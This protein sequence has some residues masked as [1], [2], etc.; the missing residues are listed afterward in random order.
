MMPLNPIQIFVADGQLPG[1]E[2][3][4]QDKIDARKIYLNRNEVAG[5]LRPG[6]IR[7]R[8]CLADTDN[9]TLSQFMAA[10]GL[11]R[12]SITHARQALLK[13]FGLRINFLPDYETYVDPDEHEVVG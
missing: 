1:S 6:S 12:T 2:F 13:T 7:H 5:M 9:M 3:T 10:T 8:V 4:D 11:S